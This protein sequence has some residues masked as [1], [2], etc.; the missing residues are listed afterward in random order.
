MKNIKKVF[1][2]VVFICMTFTMTACG[3]KNNDSQKKEEAKAPTK[4][5]VASGS[6]SVPNSY[7]ENGVH[8]GHE[9]DIWNAISKRTGI[10]VEFVTGEF[11][12]L[13]GYLDSGK[14]DTVGNTITINSSRQAKY[15]FSEP[16]AYIPEKL[17]VHSNR[18]DIKKLK[19]VAGM[20]CGFTAGSNGGNLFEKMAKKQGI[21]I[22]LVTYDS[23]ELLNQ[24][25]NQGKVDVMLLS[26]AEVAYKVK[27]GLLDAR[28]VEEDVVVG[29]KA[30]PFVK[31]NSNSEQLNK[32][33]TKAIEDMK[34]DGTLTQIYKKWYDMDFSQKP[35]DAKIGN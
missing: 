1:L 34:K 19:D 28:M 17:V 14:A 27:N 33:V 20:T 15:N 5:I 25:F 8:K 22:K 6:A 30:Y 10:K 9:V 23:S 32:T 21:D 29:A 7:V 31:G 18:T 3:G 11:N 24:A 13:F 12:T 2:F 16:Y 26:A 4:I 35:K